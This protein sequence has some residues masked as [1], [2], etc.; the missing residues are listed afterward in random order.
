MSRRASALPWEWVRFDDTGRI[1][2]PG[3]SRVHRSESGT[4]R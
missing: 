3:E 1:G 2:G 4:G